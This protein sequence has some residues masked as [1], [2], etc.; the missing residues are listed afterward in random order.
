MTP[1]THMQSRPA[2][3]APAP[4]ARLAWENVLGA[5]SGLETRGATTRFFQVLQNKG[6]AFDS[7]EGRREAREAV[8][9]ALTMCEDFVEMA[10]PNRPKD[11]A[12]LQTLRRRLELEL[13]G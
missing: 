4:A 12:R 3:S 11:R 7:K 2:R 6:G 9:H 8:C 13:W 5:V 10:Q 1:T